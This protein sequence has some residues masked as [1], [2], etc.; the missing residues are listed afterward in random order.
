MR[1]RPRK[2]RCLG[3]ERYWADVVG[4][5][6]EMFRPANLKRHNPKTVRKNIGDTY[7]GCLS[8]GVRQ[9]RELY[10]RIAGTWQGIMKGAA[11]ATAAEADEQSRVV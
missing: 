4:V 6:A 11:A 7:V 8:I 1:L 2:R 3:A 5:P 9:S 10:Q